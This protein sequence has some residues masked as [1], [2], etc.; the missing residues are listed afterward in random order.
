MP[1]LRLFFWLVAKVCKG[2][3]EVRLSGYQWRA[4]GEPILPH[5]LTAHPVYGSGGILDLGQVLNLTRLAAGFTLGPSEQCYNDDAIA[6]Q[7]WRRGQ[8]A[9]TSS[10]FWPLVPFADAACTCG[11]CSEPR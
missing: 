9:L 4:R 3:P 2:E 11:A 10:H 8:H 1:S 6:V 7:L 5:E